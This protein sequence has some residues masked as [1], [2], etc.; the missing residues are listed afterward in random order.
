M[1]PGEPGDP[2]LVVDEPPDDVACRWAFLG[3]SA[4]RATRAAECLCPGWAGRSARVRGLGCRVRAVRGESAAARRRGRAGA[5]GAPR[6]RAARTVAGRSTS[7]ATGGG[8][9]PAH[10]PATPAA[11]AQRRCCCKDVAPAG[12]GPRPF[13]V[14]A[15]AGGE[16]VCEYTGTVL[17]SAAR[18]LEDKSYLMR[19]GEGVFVDARTHLRGPRAPHQ[20]Q[21]RQT[22][23]QRVVRQ[24][25]QRATRPRR[26]LAADCG[27]SRIMR[28]PRA[29]LLPA[30][31]CAVAVRAPTE[32]AVEARCASAS[33]GTASHDPCCVRVLARSSV[34]ERRGRS[35]RWSVAAAPW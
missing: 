30:P 13:A 18:S 34:P 19:L 11:A 15:F 16:L 24:A 33:T 17:D 23:A 12:C 25:A 9:E 3:V 35:R 20:R 28:V 32:P 6:A 29:T 21:P 5:V 4:L 22:R 31:T 26:R 1:G 8:D 14:R 7:L 27:W 2:R 10:R